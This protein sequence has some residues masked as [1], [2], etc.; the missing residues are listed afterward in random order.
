MIT[1]AGSYKYISMSRNILVLSW[2][3]T[4]VLGIHITATDIGVYNCTYKTE[5]DAWSTSNLSLVVPSTD[6]ISPT[7]NIPG[8][9]L[10]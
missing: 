10:W 9:N 6:G 1:S 7:E 8:A 5:W 3:N 4:F 2:V